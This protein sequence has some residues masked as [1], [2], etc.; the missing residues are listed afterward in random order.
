[1]EECIGKQCDPGYRQL[2]H[3]SGVLHST[4][5]HLGKVVLPLGTMVSS[6]LS[7]QKQISWRDLNQKRGVDSY[8]SSIKTWRENV[9]DS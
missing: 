9:N 4:I 5:L 8:S 1:M 7:S 6:S 3:K 2:N